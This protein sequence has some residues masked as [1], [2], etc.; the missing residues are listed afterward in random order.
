MNLDIVSLREKMA[1]RLRPDGS[2][3]LHGIDFSAA[4]MYL[5]CPAQYRFRYIDGLRRPPSIALTEGTSHHKAVEE[6]NREKM[7]KGRQL[8]P[9]DMVG[10]FE[11]T[12]KSGI[13]TAEKEADELKLSLDWEGESEDKVVKRAKILLADYAANHSPKIR[14]TGAEERFAVRVNVPDVEEFLL[15]GQ[16]DLEE[17]DDKDKEVADYKVT[18]R[19]RSSRDVDESL[20]LSVYSSVRKAKKVSIVNFVKAARPY[21]TRIPSSRGP[22]DWLWAQKVVASAVDGI[23]RGAFPLTAPDPMAWWCSERFCGFW[24][25]CRGRVGR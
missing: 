1:P 17:G 2:V 25:K 6:D 21:V 12:F 11:E 4:D 3:E 15:Y 10:I 9:S 23:R 16:I 5:R 24:G 7:K 19:P 22:Q 8:K 18:G 13:K 20:Q 14:P